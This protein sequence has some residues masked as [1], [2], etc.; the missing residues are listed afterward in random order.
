MKSWM[1]DLNNSENELK[2]FSLFCYSNFQVFD[3]FLFLD[4]G[5]FDFGFFGFGFF[6]VYCFGLLAAF[7]FHCFLLFGVWGDLGSMK[8]SRWL[9]GTIAQ[10][11]LFALIIVWPQLNSLKRCVNCFC[12]DLLHYPLIQYVKLCYTLN[13]RLLKIAWSYWMKCFRWA[14][15]FK[16][17]NSL[18]C[19]SGTPDVLRL[20]SKMYLEFIMLLD[21][22]RFVLVLFIDVSFT[23][24]LRFCFDVLNDCR[25]L[26]WDWKEF[27]RTCSVID[28]TSYFLL[29][30]KGDFCLASLTMRLIDTDDWL[31][32]EP[33]FKLWGLK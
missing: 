12:L 30:L 13:S 5:F 18:N 10:V 24:W 27:V 3:D 6:E 31:L 15:I 28:S 1:S 32:A 25:A 2:Q 29:L 8:R 20:V 7:G 14:S 16:W 22:F 9:S 33:L 17:D 26:S 21:M 11:A 19:F 23:L 4:F